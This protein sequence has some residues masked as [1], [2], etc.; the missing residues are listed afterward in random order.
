V[1]NNHV[2]DNRVVD[3][4]KSG[5]AR[6]VP[7]HAIFDENR[8]TGNDYVGAVQ[9]EWQNRRHSWSDW[10]GFGNDVDGTYRD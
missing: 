5:A 2:H 8:F 1:R 9:W 7:S 3:S 10:Q 6:D 4:G